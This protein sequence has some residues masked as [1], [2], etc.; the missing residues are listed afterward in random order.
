[1]TRRIESPDLILTLIPI[2]LIIFAL[3]D[4]VGGLGLAYGSLMTGLF[5]LPYKWTQKH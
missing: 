5:V 4:P 2:G 1:M 3:K